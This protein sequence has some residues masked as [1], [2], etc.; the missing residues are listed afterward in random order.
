MDAVKD[1]LLATLFWWT[2]LLVLTGR[3]GGMTTS[4]AYG[5]IC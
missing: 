4:V 2:L 5:L 1:R 3:S